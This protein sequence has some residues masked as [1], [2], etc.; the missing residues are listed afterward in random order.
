MG[1][2]KRQERECTWPFFVVKIKESNMKYTLISAALLPAM[3][4][5]Q[6]DGWER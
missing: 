6:A 4:S 3:S 2:T 5:V 1:K